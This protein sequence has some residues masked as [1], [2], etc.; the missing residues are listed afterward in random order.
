MPAGLPASLYGFA[1][2]TG[3][4]TNDVMHPEGYTRQ[5]KSTALCPG[6]NRLE[7][8]LRTGT[9]HPDDFTTHPAWVTAKRVHER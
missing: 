2:P 3:S 7:S 4:V 6:W 1:I 9:M 8:P 5:E